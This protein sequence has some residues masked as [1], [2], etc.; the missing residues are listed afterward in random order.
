MSM[1]VRALREEEWELF[2]DLR[3]LALRDAPDA[4]RE[5]YETERGRPASDWSALVSNTAGH[6]GAELLIAEHHGRAV[7]VAFCRIR[8]D[9]ET[10]GIGAMWVVPDMRRCGIGRGLVAAALSWGRKRGARSA[11]LW[12]TEGNV[13]ADRLFRDA[14]FEPTGDT[15]SLREGSPVGILRMHRTA[16]AFGAGLRGDR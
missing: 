9:G 11:D 10:L 12:I 5:T 14:G 13:A 7:G 16:A 3:L 4:F 1:S 15:G 6:A 2:R 8:E